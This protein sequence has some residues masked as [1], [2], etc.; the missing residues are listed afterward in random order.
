MS[1][2]SWFYSRMWAQKRWERLLETR[3]V[4]VIWQTDGEEVELPEIV[5]LPDDLDLTNEAISNYLSDEYG[6]LVLDWGVIE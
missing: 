3:T 6:W 1:N 4:K 2:L 5:K